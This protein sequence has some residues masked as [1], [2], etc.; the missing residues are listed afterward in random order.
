MP[1]FMV[2]THFLTCP[3][4]AI[5]GNLC[6]ELVATQGYSDDSRKEETRLEGITTNL[7]AVGARPVY[8]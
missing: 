3:Q 4:T 7:E 8:Q 5:C 2:E 6:F 1:E